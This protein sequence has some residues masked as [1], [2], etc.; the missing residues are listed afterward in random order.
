MILLFGG[1]MCVAFYNNTIVQNW[2]YAYN[3]DHAHVAETLDHTFRHI[4]EWFENGYDQVCQLCRKICD[5]VYE[6]RALLFFAFSAAFACWSFPQLFLAGF[7][8]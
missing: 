4:K 5:F 3:G 7:E 1:I 6:N 2:G 8:I